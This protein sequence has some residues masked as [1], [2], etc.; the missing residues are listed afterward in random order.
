MSVAASMKRHIAAFERGEDFDEESGLLHMAHAAWNA[1]AIVSYYKHRPEFDDRKH[2]YLNV[3]KI[4]LDIDEVI[5]DFTAGWGKL[6]K[7]DDRPECWNYHRNMGKEFKR[8]NEEKILEDFY[9]SLE[10]KISPNDLPFE[11]HCYVT[12]RPVPTELTEKWLEKH[13]FP[14]SKV[15]TVPLGT[16]KVNALKEAG[17][18]V[19]VDDAFH[20]FTELNKAGILCYL[21]D[22]PHN[23]RYNVGYKRIKS[24]KELV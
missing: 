2:S 17:V 16:S 6:H 15:I 3:P 7:V 21:F 14:G 11:P 12:S 9:L 19:F 24:L 5:C 20:N 8:M 22:A 23:R 1:L 18:E 10:P 4:G 13:K